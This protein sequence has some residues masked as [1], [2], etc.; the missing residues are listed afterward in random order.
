MFYIFIALIRYKIY[1]VRKNRFLLFIYYFIT[2]SQNRFS[3]KLKQPF[4]NH[5]YLQD[6][7]S[8]MCLTNLTR[9]NKIDLYPKLNDLDHVPI[10]TAHQDTQTCPISLI[11]IQ[12]YF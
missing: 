4:P 1:F 3:K 5:T 9:T 8:F 10:A 12:P 6:N 11:D 2:S 7:N